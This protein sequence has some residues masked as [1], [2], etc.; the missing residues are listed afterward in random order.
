MKTIINTVWKSGVLASL[1]LCLCASFLAS[2]DSGDNEFPDFDYQSV[3]FANQYALRTL[4]LG[5]EE[6]ADVTVDNEHCCYI[7]AAWSG[8]YDNRKDVQIA[9]S[10]DPSLCEGLY[11]KGTTTPV[12]PMPS[13]YYEMES[14][15]INIPAG[16][17]QGGIKVHFTDAFF[18]DPLSATTHYVIPVRMNGVVGADSVLTEKATVLY[19]VKFANEWQGE[20]LRRGVDNITISGAA[21]QKVRHTQYVKDGEVVDV[22]TVAYRGNT[23]ALSVK[24]SKGNDQKFTLRLT[25]QE[26]GTCAISSATSGV[27]ISGTGHF[28]AK[29]EKNSLGGKDRNALY[30]DYSVDMPGAAITVATKDT[31]VLRSRNILGASTFDAEKK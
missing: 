17:V 2:C 8:G 4:E 26:D 12:T 10:V 25:F 7:N 15:T 21:Q 3:Y 31:L 13:N 1:Q 11:F 6:F 16:K 5:E 28:A 30:L 23:L 20:Y 22:N 29:G 14:T 27:N 9:C 19:C 24:D 18:A